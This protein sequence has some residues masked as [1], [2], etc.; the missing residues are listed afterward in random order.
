MVW[1]LLL[2]SMSEHL[3]WVHLIL[4]PAE[5]NNQLLLPNLLKR[6]RVEQCEIGYLV[7]KTS[8]PFSI[9]EC[10]LFNN[11]LHLLNPHTASMEFGRKTIRKTID[12]MFIPHSN[13]KI[14]I[15]L[16]IKHLSFTVDAWTSP[17]TQ[18]FMAITA[19]KITPKWK[20]LDV[21]IG[22]PEVKH[23]FL[24]FFPL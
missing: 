11:L 15:I 18:A 23:N 21:V 13:H 2:K 16:A 1:L 6:Q 12:M 17:N 14:Q 8:L 22:M 10:P 7:A 24:Y 20:M 3:R 4:P 19:H 9:V 5:E